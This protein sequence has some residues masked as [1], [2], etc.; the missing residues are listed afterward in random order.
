[1]KEIKQRFDQLIARECLAERPECLLVGG[2]VRVA[3]SEK[4]FEAKTVGDLKF[5]LR[6]TQLVKILDDEGLEHHQRAIRR[7]AARPA[8]LGLW[9]AREDRFEKR[10]VNDLIEPGQGVAH[11]M[12]FFKTR[13]LVKKT[14]LIGFDILSH[15]VRILVASAI[16]RNNSLSFSA[17]KAK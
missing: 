12:Q 5:E 17:P 8:G 14:A 9:D 2:L 4:A 7:P 15:C 16:G 13:G 6:I 1:M 3:Q 11:L 10:P